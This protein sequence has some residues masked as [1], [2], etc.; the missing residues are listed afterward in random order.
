M[1]S[2]LKGG[3]F[4]GAVLGTGPTVD[5]DAHITQ[6]LM[7]ALDQGHQRGGEPHPDRSGRTEDQGGA[8]RVQEAGGMGQWIVV[9]PGAE[10]GGKFTARQILERVQRARRQ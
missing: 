5:I 9:S 2:M 6:G 3:G 8:R 10:P 1:R 4:L 7:D